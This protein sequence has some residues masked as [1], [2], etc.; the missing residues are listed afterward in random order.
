MLL[1]GNSLSK[2]CVDECVSERIILDIKTNLH[3]YKRFV[4]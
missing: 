2:S 4:K 1:R 3:M